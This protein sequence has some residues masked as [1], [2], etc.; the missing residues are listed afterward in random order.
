MGWGR[1]VYP[2]LFNNRKDVDLNN[3]GEEWEKLNIINKKKLQHVL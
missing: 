3:V 2:P 1:G